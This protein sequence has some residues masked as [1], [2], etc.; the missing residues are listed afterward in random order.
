MS[1]WQT[2]ETAPTDGTA[3]ILFT[4]QRRRNVWIGHFTEVVRMENGVEVFRH[5][6]W[7]GTNIWPTSDADHVPTHWQP[8]P[9]PPR[10]ASA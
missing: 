8:L 6:G 9:E 2:I 4:S 10:E 7:T 1:E 5:A 3:V